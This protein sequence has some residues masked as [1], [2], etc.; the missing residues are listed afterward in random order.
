MSFGGQLMTLDRSLHRALRF[1][2]ML[3]LPFMLLAG[4][5]RLLLSYEFLRFEYQRPGFPSDSY[6]FTAADR[7]AYG[8]YAIDYL[9]NAAPID[10]LANLRLSAAKCWGA[11]AG[12]PDCPLFNS[13]ELWHL[14]DVKDLTTT[15]FSLA[16]GCAG[17]MAGAAL[18][19][20]RWTQYQRDIIVGWRRGSQLMLALL[21]VGATLVLAGWDLAFDRFHELLFP[22]GT[23]RFLF[24]DSLI[25]LYPEQLFIDAALLIACFCAAGAL[26]VF[27]S[28]VYWE[29]RHA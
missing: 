26:L 17:I 12:A 22:A 19:S 29:K 20:A 15:I 16:L 27:F 7:L 11:V 25:R 5:A 1:F 18:F 24:S 3:A 21:V 9:F 2:A 10:S 4:S 6:G 13:R 23:W 28:S 8:F 14:Q